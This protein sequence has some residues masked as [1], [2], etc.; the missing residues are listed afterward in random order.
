MVLCELF[1]TQQQAQKEEPLVT[2]TRK[3]ADSLFAA[4]TTVELTNHHHAPPPRYF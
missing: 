1:K 3:L 4:V 2:Y